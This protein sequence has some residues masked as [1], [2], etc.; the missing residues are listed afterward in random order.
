MLFMRTGFGLDQPSFTRKLMDVVIKVTIPRSFSLSYTLEDHIFE[1][2][3]DKKD[4]G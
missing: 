1:D 2:K 4:L 3:K